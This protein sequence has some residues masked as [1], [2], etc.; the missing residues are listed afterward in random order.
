M[1]H[2]MDGVGRKS[3]KWCLKEKIVLDEF[4]E[5][6]YW[7]PLA[8]DPNDEDILYTLIYYPRKNPEFSRLCKLNIRKFAS[9]FRMLSKRMPGQNRIEAFPIVMPRQWLPTP[10]PRLD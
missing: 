7:K 6:M 10:V 2:E 5:W 8:F 1:T 3:V 9:V 4:M